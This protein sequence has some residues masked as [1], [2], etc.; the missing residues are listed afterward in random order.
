MFARIVVT[1]RKNPRFTTSTSKNN[2]P[3]LLLS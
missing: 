2:T 3:I 1:Q